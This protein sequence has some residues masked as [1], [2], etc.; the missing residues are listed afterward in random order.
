[1]HPIIQ[2]FIM[3]YVYYNTRFLFLQDITFKNFEFFTLKVF[4]GAMYVNIRV[5][6]CAASMIN[7]AFSTLY[8]Y[9]VFLHKCVLYL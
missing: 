3:W 1:M 9:A 7:S 2:L 8:C 5:I 6:L 4:M